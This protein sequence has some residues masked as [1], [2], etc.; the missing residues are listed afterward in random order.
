MRHERRPAGTRWIAALV[1]AVVALAATAAGAAGAAPTFTDGNG[2]HIVSEKTLSSRL[3]ELRMTTPLL[4][5]PVS[6]R[7]LVPSDYG[8]ST[9]RYPVVYL[10]H[11][12]SGGAADWTTMG[13]AEKTTATS[14]FIVAMPD[15]GYDSDGGGWFTDWYRGGK[16]GV[17]KWESF[18][19]G[20]LIPFVDRN[21]R[22]VAARRGRAIYGLSQGGF[23]SM[24]YASR[25]PDMFVASGAFSG[26]VDTTADAEAQALTTPII[27]ATTTGLDGESDPD[28]MFGS[29]ATEN[30]N[31]A[32]HDPATLAANLR[33]QN[34]RLYTGN[35]FPGPLDGPVANPGAEA[36]EGGV[37]ILNGL[38]HTR[39]DG[40]KIPSV[41][42]DYG[43]GT[44]SWPYW[45]RDFRDVAP[46]LAKVFADPPAAPAKV[47]Y[48]SGD[49]HWSAWGYDVTF[50]RPAREFSELSDGDARGFALAGSGSATVLTPPAYLAGSRAQV[51]VK[52]AS[53]T[54]GT[55]T[56]TAVADATGR[57]ALTV[58][59]GPGN[60]DQ[61]YTA[62]SEAAGGPKV[63]TT[64]VAIAGVPRPAA[65]TLR[66][67][68]LRLPVPVGTRLR[69]VR[70]S[71]DGTR[72]LGS[73][74]RGRFV[75]VPL[76]RLGPGSH[77]IVVTARA[78]ATRRRLGRAVSVSRTVGCG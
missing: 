40:L 78:S 41:Y 15:A 42:D 30:V 62:A 31:W 13:D 53:G 20:E 56:S 36:I 26:A 4:A 37:H 43:P 33:G 73:R 21:L 51:S 39:L 32:A 28:A 23:G 54:P 58:P 76:K 6:M 17:P 8:T 57:L 3:S 71:A 63:F 70:T 12:T 27:Q 19:V 47:D 2:I 75:S 45:A 22:T 44:H 7:I 64:H 69:R 50:K 65:C 48:R 16:G 52:T 55:A 10:F 49:D 14:P 25:H 38:F 74:R 29:R 1:L 11:G 46:V 59:L 34:I 68:T 35:G 72:R 60:P 77:R 24:S 66:R 5:K 61:Q 67:V 18:H 9:K